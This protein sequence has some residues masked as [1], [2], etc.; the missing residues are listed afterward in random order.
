MNAGSWV[1]GKNVPENRN[2]GMIPNLNSIANDVSFVHVNVYASIGAPNASPVSTAAGSA[3]AAQAD[4][5]APNAAITA[6]NTAEFMVSRSVVQSRWPW[7]RSAG[8]SGDA[9]AAW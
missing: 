7:N 9:I 1:T 4:W 8:R 2:S 3:A 6:R 5:T